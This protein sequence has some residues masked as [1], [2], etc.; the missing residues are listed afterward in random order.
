MW[1]P[2]K[3]IRDY[4]GSVFTLSHTMSGLSQPYFSPCLIPT[5]RIANPAKRHRRYSNNRLKSWD[6]S[7]SLDHQS[8]L[9]DTR[10]MEHM[11]YGLFSLSPWPSAHRDWLTPGRNNMISLTHG[12]SYHWPKSAWSMVSSFTCIWFQICLVFG[13]KQTILGPKSI[14]KVICSY[15]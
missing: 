11:L 6:G 13:W 10:A 9:G 3:E 15:I 2:S 7:F 4:W 12:L 5:P 14:Q 8:C 1:F